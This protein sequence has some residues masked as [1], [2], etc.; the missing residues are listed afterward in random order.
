M[1]TEHEKYMKQV[2]ESN[3]RSAKLFAKRAKQDSKNFIKTQKAAK[4]ADGE[5]K[6]QLLS[7]ASYYKRVAA[8]EKKLA[9]FY[10]GI[11]KRGK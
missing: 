9:T 3:K 2:K 5:R 6:R 7:D 1:K 10:K 11:N 8:K 4:K